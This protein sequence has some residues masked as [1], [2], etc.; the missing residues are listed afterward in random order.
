MRSKRLRASE[1]IEHYTS[2]MAFYSVVRKSRSYVFRWLHENVKDKR[3]LDYCCGEGR[4]SLEIAGLGAGQVVG[5]DLS[6]VSLENAR[7]RCREAGVEKNTLFFLMDAEEMAFSDSAFDI[8]HESGAL[9]HLDLD[10][11]YAEMARVLR[12]NGCCICVEALRHNPVIQYYRKK[13]PHLR[14]SWETANILG[15][16]EIEMARKFFG[17]IRLDGF[18][19]LATLGA[20][21]FRKFAGFDLLLRILEGID[22]VI[23]K[24]PWIQWAA[25]QAVFVLGDPI[26]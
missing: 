10:R 4:A 14:T 15:R 20:V 19:H 6:P 21:P 23:L 12:P 5:I 8:I 17:T 24:R 7:K 9:H 13:T 25:W 16:A 22:D 2:N 18:F 3:V 11:A 1:W 26:K